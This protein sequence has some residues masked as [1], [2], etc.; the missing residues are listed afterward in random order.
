MSVPISENDRQTLKNIALAI[1]P[2]EDAFT[3]EEIIGRL[4][5]KTGVEPERAK[6]GF[7]MML[8]SG[9]IEHTGHTLYYLGGSTPF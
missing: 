9:A 3:Q 1:V 7:N 6:K 8:Q 2:P 5:D 4:I